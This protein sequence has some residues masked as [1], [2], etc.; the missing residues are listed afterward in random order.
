MALLIDVDFRTLD[1]H[2]STGL[3][4]NTEP[5]LSSVKAKIVPVLVTMT[6]VLFSWVISEKFLGR[7]IL[8]AVEAPGARAG[9]GRR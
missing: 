7:G 6:L 2:V 5:F 1:F 9:A 8:R 4:L 3:Q